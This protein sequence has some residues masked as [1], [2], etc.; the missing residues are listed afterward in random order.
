MAIHFQGKGGVL[1]APLWDKISIRETAGRKGG[2]GFP[3]L[4]LPFLT[5]ILPAAICHSLQVAASQVL[6]CPRMSCWWQK[7]WRQTTTWCNI[8]WK[9]PLHSSQPN[10]SAR[11]LK[12]KRWSHFFS[13]QNPCDSG[14]DDNDEDD[15]DEDE[16]ISEA[17]AKVNPRVWLSCDFSKRCKLFPQ[18]KQ[19]PHV[20][21]QLA[22]QYFQYT[23]N[24]PSFS[25]LLQGWVETTI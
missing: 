11:R 14:E 16:D 19:F 21:P 25:N 13:W 7:I 9:Q 22:S 10:S 24:W 1:S 23:T 2:K 15:N 20:K 18:W 12:L 17:E 5:W 8:Q 4:P 3:V 6:N